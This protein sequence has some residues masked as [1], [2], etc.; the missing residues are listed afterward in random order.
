ML[1]NVFKYTTEELLSIAI[2][3]ATIK[4]ATKLLPIPGSREATLDSSNL[5][6]FDAIIQDAKSGAMGGKKSHKWCP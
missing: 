1:N 4:E 5:A 6:L 3:Y 2:Q